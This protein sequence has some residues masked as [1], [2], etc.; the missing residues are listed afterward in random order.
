MQLSGGSSTHLLTLS[1]QAKDL[2]QRA[3]LMSGCVYNPWAFGIQNEHLLIMF[4]LGIKRLFKINL[5]L[6]IAYFSLCS[7]GNG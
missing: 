2:Y 7:N 1:P 3:I 5:Y 6:T 4:S